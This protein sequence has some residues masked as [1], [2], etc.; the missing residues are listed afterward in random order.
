MSGYPREPT[1]KVRL[2]AQGTQSLT[3]RLRLTLEPECPRTEL[4]T[5]GENRRDERTQAPETLKLFVA[6]DI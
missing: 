3:A 2:G 4:A 6:S 5:A 1:V